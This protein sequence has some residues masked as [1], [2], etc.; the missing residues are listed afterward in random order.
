M[1]DYWL[2]W[3]NPLAFREMHPF[4]DIFHALILPGLHPSCTLQLL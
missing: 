1:Y 3:Q 4:Q 2:S